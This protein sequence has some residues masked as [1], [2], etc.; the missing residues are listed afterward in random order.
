[1]PGISS[2][3]FLPHQGH[4]HL[5]RSTT[6]RNHKTGQVRKLD[7]TR[8]RYR[9]ALTLHAY[10]LHFKMLLWIQAYI[11][12]PSDSILPNQ[13]SHSSACSCPS[14]PSLLQAF[15]ALYNAISSL[16]S[17]IFSFFTAFPSSR[18]LLSHLARSCSL[19]TLRSGPHD[20]SV[21]PREV[22][23]PLC[24]RSW[25]DGC[26]L[27]LSLPGTRADIEAEYQDTRTYNTKPIVLIPT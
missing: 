27:S 5:F 12:R 19:F 8:R 18:C 22:G 15:F 26:S 7:L 10:S 21:L 23:S 6:T 11:S 1:M 25:K 16:F 4:K 24:I 2:C 20:V 14:C 13:I 9:T 3:L 17:V